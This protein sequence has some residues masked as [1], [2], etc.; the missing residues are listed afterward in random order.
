MSEIPLVAGIELGGTKCICILGSGPEDI[1]DEVRIPTTSPD[2]TLAAIEAVLDRW[3][4]Y[5]ALGIASFGPVSIDRRGSVEI[6]F[7]DVAA[8]FVEAGNS[9]YFGTVGPQS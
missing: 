8:S 1:R 9:Y 2:E 7:S 3:T 4:G 5:Q 6:Q